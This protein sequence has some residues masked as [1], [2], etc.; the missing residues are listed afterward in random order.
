MKWNNNNNDNNPWGSG[1]NKNPGVQ[2][3]LETAQIEE[4]LKILLEKQKIDL[5][6]LN[7]VADVTFQY[8]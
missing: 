8:L 7:L 5:A 1:G 4:I 2:E 3:G 6:I